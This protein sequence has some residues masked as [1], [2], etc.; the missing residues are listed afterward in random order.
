MAH[1]AAKGFSRP[2]PP[3]N[4]FCT[5][6]SRDRA[7]AAGRRP[8]RSARFSCQPQPADA[9]WQARSH[10]QSDES[11]VP[12]VR[13]NATIP[14]SRTRSRSAAVLVEGQASASH[15]SQTGPSAGGCRCVW[16]RLA[17]TDQSEGYGDRL[18]LRRGLKAASVVAR[19]DATRSI[20]NSSSRWPGRAAPVAPSLLRVGAAVNGACY[21]RSSSETPDV[22]A[23]DRW[24]CRPSDRS[25]IEPGAD[26]CRRHR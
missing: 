14:S 1:A 21:W 19:S 7:E 18:R 3:A 10:S 8:A 6:H 15:P 25:R 4:P 12:P 26:A 11:P 24:S 2:P 13:T 22:T 23:S 5:D 16:R 9:R 17:A 20:Q